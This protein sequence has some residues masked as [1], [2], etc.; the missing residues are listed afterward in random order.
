MLLDDLGNPAPSALAKALGVTVRT[1]YRWLK[2]PD[3]V[4]RT[5]LLALFWITRWGQSEIHCD[6][7]NSESLAQA[8]LRNQ[9]DEISQLRT[10]LARVLALGNTGAAND[11]S[12]LVK[13]LAKVLPFRARS[14]PQADTSC[15]TE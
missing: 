6:L 12:Q 11:A 4:P 2:S 14:T 13:P 7:V 10:E 9:R 5:V 8:Q 1:V 15:C 3:E